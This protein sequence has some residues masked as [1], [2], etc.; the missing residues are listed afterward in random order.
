MQYTSQV[1]MLICTVPVR[2]WAVNREASGHSGLIKS[3]VTRR[4]DRPTR[5]STGFRG[6][7]L[8]PD[9]NNGSVFGYICYALRQKT[10]IERKNSEFHFVVVMCL[11]K[12]D[13]VVFKNN[14]HF[15]WW[16]FWWQIK[17]S[18]VASQSLIFTM[19]VLVLAINME[20]RIINFWKEI[21]VSFRFIDRYLCVN[22]CTNVQLDNISACVR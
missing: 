15:D 11:P 6:Q 20:S 5:R 22:T 16:P 7:A 10:L 18:Y 14:T 3:E 2:K 17:I 21:V 1:H 13:L 9:C 8:T 4:N 12:R 19:E